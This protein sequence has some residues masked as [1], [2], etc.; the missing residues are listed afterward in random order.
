MTHDYKRHG[1][2]TL[3]ADLDISTGHVV[4]EC[5]PRHCQQEFLRFLRF[6]KKIEQSVPEELDIHVVLD[7]YGTHKTAA[8]KRW[9]AKHPRVMFHFTLTSASWLNLVERVFAELSQHALKRLA[10][11]SVGELIDAITAY[12]A[13][14]NENP[15]PFVWTATV[16]SIVR[17]VNRGL[18]TLASHH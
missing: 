9:L 3:F 15:K 8:V 18:T 17:K 7:N 16:D 10:V 13:R 6:L 1:T 4:H 12:L 2:T 11:T 5:M 14:R